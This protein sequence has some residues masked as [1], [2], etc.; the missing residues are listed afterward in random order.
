MD[1][2]TQRRLKKWVANLNDNDSIVA[3][4][5]AEKL[6]K[7]GHPAAIPDLIHAMQT[8]HTNVASA[9]AQ[10]LGDIGDPSALPELMQTARKHQDTIVQTAAI[11]ALG[12]IGDP[13]AIPALEEI[14]DAYLAH[15]RGATRYDRIRGYDY[16]LLTTAVHALKQIGT[17]KALQVA[18]KVDSI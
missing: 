9:A 14:I 5:A 12:D 16:A 4:S 10:A 13:R 3:A 8:R 7:L 6:G 17:R 15:K 18:S 11:Q 2:L 1:D